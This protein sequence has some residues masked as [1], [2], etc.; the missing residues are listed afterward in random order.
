[1]GGGRPLVAGVRIILHQ[2]SIILELGRSNGIGA[3]QFGL[4]Y[5]SKRNQNLSNHLLPSR[6]SNLFFSVSPVAQG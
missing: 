2:R 4:H 6:L 1:M 3:L 5:L